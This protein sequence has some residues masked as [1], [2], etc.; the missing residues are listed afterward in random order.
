MRRRLGLTSY[1]IFGFGL[2]GV[3]SASFSN[4]S[5]F[6]VPLV[7]FGAVFLLYKFPPGRLRMNGPA[8][9]QAKTRK[10]KKPAPF[11]VITGNKRDNDQEPP[12]YH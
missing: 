9:Y 10:P 7:I 6:L 11:R 8:I 3:V 1:L 12:K 5:V 2:I 4:P